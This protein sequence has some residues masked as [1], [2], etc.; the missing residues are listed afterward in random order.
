MTTPTN[1]PNRPRP[2]IGGTHLSRSWL[3]ITVALVV[4]VGMVASA[5]AFLGSGVERRP[6]VD[7]GPVAAFVARQPVEFRD[8]GFLLMRLED[9]GFVAFARYAPP[10]LNQ[11]RGCR[12]EWQPER[13]VSGY[14]A[15][16]GATPVPASLQTYF[17]ATGVWGE[18]CLGSVW[19]ARGELISG[20]TVRNL[21]RFPVTVSD[22][23]H[24]RVDTRT[25]RCSGQPCRH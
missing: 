12:I 8:D 25:L 7:A 24:V 3:T 6:V 17:E 4:T 16:R 13:I 14:H 23:G 20:P 19:D 2:R 1:E 5:F 22:D 9:G 15:G 11:L 18:G 21:D 10:T